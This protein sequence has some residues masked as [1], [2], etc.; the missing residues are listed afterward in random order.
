MLSV[1][2]IVLET[3]HPSQQLP[4]GIVQDSKGTS[5]ACSENPILLPRSEWLASAQKLGGVDFSFVAFLSLEL[6]RTNKL[7]SPFRVI[8]ELMETS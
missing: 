4:Q 2:V 7:A 1:R 6:F 5:H 8:G 3:K